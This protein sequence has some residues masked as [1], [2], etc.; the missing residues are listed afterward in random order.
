MKNETPEGKAESIASLYS[1]PMPLDEIAMEE[2]IYIIYDNYGSNTFDG[3]TWYVPEMDKFFIHINQERG[4]T[5]YNNKGRFTLAHE[6]GHY[7]IDH[8]RHALENGKMQPHYHRY[9]PFGHNEEWI[10]EREADAF[11]AS[12]LMPRFLFEQEFQ[13]KEFSGE[14]IQSIAAK[15]HVSFSA[16][17]LRYM[18]L[19]Y[20]PILLIYAEDGIIKW[21]MRSDD[22]P[23]TR[24]RYG[25]NKVPENTVIGEYFYNH[26]STTCNKSEIVYAE[27]CFH[28]YN[29]EQNRIEFYEYCIPYGKQAFSIFWEKV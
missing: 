17:A 14:L 16:C 10:I 23:F 2:G 24:M 21:Q 3:I 5:A 6:L 11:A 9:E 12:L 28:T 8:H 13:G 19:N 20:I 1:V 26:D 22:F 4:N 25:T 18:K 7:F 27:D 29:E 15:F